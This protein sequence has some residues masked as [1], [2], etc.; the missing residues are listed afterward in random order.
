MNREEFINKI[1]D[2]VGDRLKDEVNLGDSW[3]GDISYEDLEL[4]FE[5]EGWFMRLHFS[6][7]GWYEFHSATY[8]FEGWT[9]GRVTC[10]CIRGEVYDPDGEPMAE[11]SEEERKMF[12]YQYKLR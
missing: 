7:S 6:V 9:E 2:Y 11:L 12:D 10:E 5:D 1:A 3:E 8:D 4:E